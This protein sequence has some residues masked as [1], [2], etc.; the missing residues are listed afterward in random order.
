MGILGWLG[1]SGRDAGTGAVPVAQPQAL[2]QGQLF[3]GISDPYLLQFL[4][5]GGVTQSGASVTPDSALKNTAVFRC[6]SLISYSIAM[7]PLHLHRDGQQ[8]EKATDHPLFRVLHRKPN[9]WQT[10]FEFRQLMQTWALTEGDAFAAKVRRGDQV[11]GLLP[12]D[13]RRTVVEQRDDLSVVYKFT[14]K[15]GGQRTLPARDVFHLR[16]FT[17]DGLRGRSL[18]KQAAEAIGLALQIERAAARLFRNGMIVGGELRMAQGKKLSQE[19]YER[20]KAS[21]E[22]REG[23][24]NA[25]RWLITEEGM[26]AHPFS[27]TAQG[28]QHHE[29][30]GHQVEE[31]ARVFGVPRPLLMVD[32]TS[33]GSGIDV[34][35]QMFVRYGLNPWFEAWEQ[36]IWRCLLSDREQDEYYAKFNAAALLRGSMKDQAE[37][38]AKGLSVNNQQPWLHQDEVRGWMDLAPRDDLPKPIGKGNEKDEPARTA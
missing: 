16:G 12:M 13:P 2:D 25:H 28:S 34:L 23:A 10:A 38:F 26:E 36:A 22:E 5:D 14:P 19:A 6:V 27:Q 11:I 29:M 7:L 24:A 35:G 30:R 3:D 4:R 17:T 1:F 37:F 32:D 9:D 15:N 8:L 18:L 20:L 33:W 21:M 31:V